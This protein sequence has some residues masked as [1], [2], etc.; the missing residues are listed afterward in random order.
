MSDEECQ[1][2]QGRHLHLVEPAP[3]APPASP[4]GE[5]ALKAFWQK[6]WRGYLLALIILWGVYGFSWLMAHEMPTKAPPSPRMQAACDNFN[7][8]CGG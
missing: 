7:P 2:A 1:P 8:L 4:Q 3:D 6:H 5:G